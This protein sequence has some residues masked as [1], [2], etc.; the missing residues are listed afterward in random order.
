LSGRRCKTSQTAGPVCCIEQRTFAL[1]FKV[2]A[3]TKRLLTFEVGV[4]NACTTVT[5]AT[6]TPGI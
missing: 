6:E 3:T 5:Q 2:L 4:G 1:S